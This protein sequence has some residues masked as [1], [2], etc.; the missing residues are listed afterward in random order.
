M[1]VNSLN[2]LIEE[3]IKL[4]IIKRYARNDAPG[5]LRMKFSHE[6]FKKLADL[7][8]TMYRLATISR[9]HYQLIAGWVT[10]KKSP[11]ITSLRQFRIN[12]GI[13]V[14]AGGTRGQLWY[15][16]SVDGLRKRLH[17]LGW[18]PSDFCKAVDIHASYAS[19]ILRGKKA[20]VRGIKIGTWEEWGNR[21]GCKF[22]VPS[23]IT[24]DEAEEAMNNNVEG[25]EEE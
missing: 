7:C 21:M 1:V 11:S 17:D 18:R 16:A 20:S 6:N 22:Y 5:M 13:A 23:Q 19:V 9:L 2:E 24:R 10:G 8:G 25:E 3:A 14:W 12:T 4:G 15:E